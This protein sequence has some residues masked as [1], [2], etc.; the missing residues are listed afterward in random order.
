MPCHAL[1]DSLYPGRPSDE[2]PGGRHT[3]SLC[4]GPRSETARL[5]GGDDLADVVAVVESGAG[6]GSARR[7]AASPIP[8]LVRPSPARQDAAD[9]ALG[10]A[11][12]AGD[13]DL[14]QSTAVQTDDVV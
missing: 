3:Q 1:V 6:A 12:P 14:G 2:S 11:H 4:A 7:S 8:D 13:L 5:P 10:H 9:R